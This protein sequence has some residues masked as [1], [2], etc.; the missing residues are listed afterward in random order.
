MVLLDTKMLE[1]QDSSGTQG[2][3]PATALR[4]INIRTVY[5]HI[6]I[7]LLPSVVHIAVVLF[8]FIYV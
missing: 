3:A 8:M 7:F 2:Y 1:I 6:T 5:V 4:N